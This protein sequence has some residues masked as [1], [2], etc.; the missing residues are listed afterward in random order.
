MQSVI[1][2]YHFFQIK[3]ALILHTVH[4]EYDSGKLHSVFEI[5]ILKF[6]SA[7]KYMRKYYSVCLYIT[8]N[9]KANVIILISINF[10]FNSSNIV[11]FWH[12]GQ[13]ETCNGQY[14]KTQNINPQKKTHPCL[15]SPA[16]NEWMNEWMNEWHQSRRQGTFIRGAF[17]FLG[18]GTNYIVCVCVCV[19][20]WWGGGGMLSCNF[21]SVIECSCWRSLKHAIAF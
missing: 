13:T 14:L 18:G 5:N 21:T 6:R 3:F 4:S 19:C 20:V 10:L 11:F 16:H 15:R 8:N 9:R 2:I 1:S 17:E 12:M 7:R